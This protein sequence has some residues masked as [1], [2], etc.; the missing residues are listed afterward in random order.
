[1]CT[2][3]KLTMIKRGPA[4]ITREVSSCCCA[5][6]PSSPPSLTPTPPAVTQ[7]LGSPRNG[8]L[9]GGGAVSVC[10]AGTS[11]SE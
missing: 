4:A 6:S 3:V 1:M 11:R 8:V 5:M 10:P 9:E 2:C 7:R